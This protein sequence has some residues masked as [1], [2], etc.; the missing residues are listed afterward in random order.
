MN[1]SGALRLQGWSRGPSACCEP[2]PSPSLVSS[3]LLHRSFSKG[4]SFPNNFY[5][6]WSLRTLCQHI[7]HQITTPPRASPLQWIWSRAPWSW[8]FWKVGKIYPCVQKVHSRWIWIFLQNGSSC[9]PS[10]AIKECDGHGERRGCWADAAERSGFSFVKVLFIHS[11]AKFRWGNTPLS[12]EGD[13]I[14]KYNHIL[15]LIL[16]CL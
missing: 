1:E 6:S 11:V 12:S 8:G 16:G 5:R 13:F 2:L 10:L 7:F 3:F 4:T 15:F 9:T 14:F